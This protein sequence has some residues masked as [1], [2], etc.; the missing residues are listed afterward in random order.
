MALK[1]GKDSLT[2][3][4]L[5][6]MLD[7]KKTRNALIGLEGLGLAEQGEMNRWSLTQRG[8]TCR[9]EVVPDRARR[10]SAMPGRAGA[11][12]LEL[13]DRPMRGNELAERLGVSHQRVHQLVVELH[14]QG[15]VKFG[16][17]QRILQ[18]V[19]R[20]GDSTP[21][22]SRNEERV[23]SAIP[24]EYA[25][26]V[27]KIRIAARLPEK[28]VRQIL[29]RLVAGG[30]VETIGGSAG[31][32]VYRIAA[33]GLRN[34]QRGEPA[35]RAEAP[36]L[37]VRSQRVRT[38][39]SAILESGSLRIKD[40]TQ[41]LRI[42]HDSINALMQYLK[43]KALVQKT[44]RELHAPYELTDKGHEALAEMTRRHAA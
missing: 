33:A 43:R 7:L 35:S 23:L 22:L 19:S 21:L 1:F 39:L 16:D 44:G 9:F 24:G 34:C 41:T 2:E 40:V 6:A 18:I 32:T 20:T 37:P 15:L 5:L 31:D 29:A 30:L 12:L 42:P 36:P 27:R 3:I 14:A 25:T 17:Q 13:L 11:R 28:E 4:A 8:E 10:N 26:N 38:V